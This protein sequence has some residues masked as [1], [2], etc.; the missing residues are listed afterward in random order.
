MSSLGDAVSAF[1][2]QRNCGMFIFGDLGWSAC[3]L[4]YCLEICF[5]NMEFI[6]PFVEGNTMI[7]I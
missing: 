6:F 5:V 3:L 4:L 2:F 1:T 7:Y